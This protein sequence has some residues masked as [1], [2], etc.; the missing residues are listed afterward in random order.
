MNLT[1]TQIDNA[2]NLEC[3]KCNS[4]LM[5]QAFVIKKISGL[6]MPDG[7]DTYLPVSV[8]ACQK[9]GHVN[10]LFAIELGINKKE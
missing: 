7:K 8:F 4:F 5:N 10:D 9:C 3:E 6:L 2:K 1:K